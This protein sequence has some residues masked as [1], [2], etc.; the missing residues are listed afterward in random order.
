MAARRLLPVEQL[1]AVE[2][3]A[4]SARAAAEAEAAR[5]GLEHMTFERLVML[6]AGPA[7]AVPNLEHAGVR[8]AGQLDCSAHLPLLRYEAY[9]PWPRQRFSIAH[10]LG[11]FELHETRR[12]VGVRSCEKSDVEPDDG[13][14][15][16]DVD[17]ELEANAFAGAFLVP[18][19]RLRRD[20]ATFGMGTG[21]MAERFGV[22]RWAM[23]LRWE[24]VQLLPTSLL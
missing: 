20:V 16:A 1:R 11:H 10:E 18:A 15:P 17:E 13:V 2:E 14:V 12:H 8:L 19:A 22:S 9:D 3:I 6:A 24:T 21:F 5:L 7:E 4:E 23:S